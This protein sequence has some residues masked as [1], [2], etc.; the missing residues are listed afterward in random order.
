MEANEETGMFIGKK[1]SDVFFAGNP[2][3]KK[4]FDKFVEIATGRGFDITVMMTVMDELDI[5][6]ENKDYDIHFELL[7]D[8]DY[9]FAGLLYSD[10]DNEGYGYGEEIEKLANELNESGI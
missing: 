7:K 4:N 9:S 10:T 3:M 2:K 1:E 6:I 5:Q 8:N